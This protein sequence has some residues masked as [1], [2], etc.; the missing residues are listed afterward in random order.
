MTG[1][2][3]LRAIAGGVL[4][5]AAAGAILLLNGRIAGVSGMLSSAMKREGGEHLW[6]PAFLAGLVAGGALLA[7]ADPGAIPRVH[8][9]SPWMLVLAGALVGFGAR[10][11]GGC[12]S[13]HGLCGVSRLSVRSVAATA[14]FVAAGAAAVA[15]ARVLP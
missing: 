7:W 9:L 8:A 12:T 1:E 10:T 5:G 15:F 3:L 2:E 11:A 4:L 6:Q 13:G 14:L